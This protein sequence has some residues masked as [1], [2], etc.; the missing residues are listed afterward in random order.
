[1]LKGEWVPY[2]ALRY[3]SASPLRAGFIW[4]AKITSAN[5]WPLPYKLQLYI[6][7]AWSHGKEY[8][9]VKLFGV[10]PVHTFRDADFIHKGIGRLYWLAF[11]PI[12][13]TSLLP[14]LSDGIHWVSGKE[15]KWNF[16]KKIE[17][18]AIVEGFYPAESESSKVQFHFD[19]QGLVNSIAGNGWR[20]RMEDY[21]IAGHGMFCP[22]YVELGREENGKLTAYMKVHIKD[23]VYS[24]F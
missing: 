1:M 9:R 23:P 11:S 14:H 3:I 20:F 10:V 15:K 21:K 16:N 5:W 6:Q 18:V 17:S 8:Q 22:M 12:F 7:N 13:P 2:S 24:Y 4:D 19:D